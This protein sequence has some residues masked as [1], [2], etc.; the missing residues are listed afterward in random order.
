LLARIYVSAG[1]TDGARRALW[2]A[3]HDMGEDQTIYDA[4]RNLL[5][6][7]DGP[8][9]AARL[10]EEHYDKRLQQLTRSIA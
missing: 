1:D 3:F 7:S 10:S 5:V 6:R 2:D 4:L 9:A 8:Q